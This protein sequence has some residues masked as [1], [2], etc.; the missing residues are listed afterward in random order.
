[1][2]VAGFR[3]PG[4]PPASRSPLAA[5][6]ARGDAR[7]VQLLLAA[8]SIRAHA[9]DASGWTALM[10]AASNRHAVTVLLLLLLLLQSC[11]D[12]D[13]VNNFGWT[14]CPPITALQLM[15][16]PSVKPETTRASAGSEVLQDIAVCWQGSYSSYALRTHLKRTVLCAIAACEGW[17]PSSCVECGAQR[18]AQYLHGPATACCAQLLSL[19][20]ISSARLANARANSRGVHAI[21]LVRFMQFLS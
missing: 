10:L 7:Q 18:S 19:H 21:S 16:K 9:V 6:C 2:Q 12:V 13:A 1:M 15:V 8:D 14:L 3:G 5:A 11:S 17:H 20:L 4:N